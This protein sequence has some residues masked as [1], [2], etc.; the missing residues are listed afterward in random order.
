MV[1]MGFTCILS[2]NTCLVGCYW[3]FKTA[4]IRYISGKEMK[5]VSA[6]EAVRYSPGI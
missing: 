4:V 2:T 3:D 5:D 6:Y 1:L